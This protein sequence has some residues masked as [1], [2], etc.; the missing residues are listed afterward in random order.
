[1]SASFM[2]FVL[3]LFNIYNSFLAEEAD[4][5]ACLDA[6]EAELDARWEAE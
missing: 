6:E 3:S 5:E 4:L 1:M 2:L